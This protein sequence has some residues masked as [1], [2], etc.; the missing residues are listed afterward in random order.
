M[1]D[2]YKY[3]WLLELMMEYP[4][5]H[6]TFEEISERWRENK[7]FSR[8]NDL[9]RS[10]FNR[11]RD[12]ISD[13][14]H[15]TIACKKWQ[16]YWYYYIED[17]EYLEGN[18]LGEWLIKNKSIKNVI[19]DYSSISDKILVESNSRGQEYLKYI[20]PAI[21]GEYTIMILYKSFTDEEPFPRKI[22]PYALRLFKNR[23]YVIGEESYSAEIRVYA[24]DRICG[25][26]D[27]TER[28][29]FEYPKDFSPIS[30]FSLSYG[31]FVGPK[32]E[33]TKIVLRAYDKQRFY[34]AS[35]PMHRTQRII[36]ETEKYTDFE[37]KLVPTIDFIDAILGAGPMLEVLEPADLRDKVKARI[38]DMLKRY[39]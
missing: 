26:D 17:L 2:I 11:W 35:L 10:T 31:M 27:E 6:L 7:D 5:S 33:F 25:I 13:I 12:K 29:Q 16:D 18:N 22:K 4:I 9:P 36:N 32:T 21:H 8:G 39:N 30:F 38:E 34:M 14:F 24:L 15:I 1:D 3:A 20:L 37:L 28:E 23:W 19:S